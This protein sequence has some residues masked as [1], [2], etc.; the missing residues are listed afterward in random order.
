MKKVLFDNGVPKG[1]ASSVVGHQ[2]T[3]SRQLGWHLLK[4]GDLL[5]QAETGGFDVLL[6]TDK[7][8]QHQQ[9]LK[10]R[11]IAL[12]VL[13]EQRWSMVQQFSDQIVDAVNKAEPGSYTEV[14]IPWRPKNK[15][16]IVKGEH[17]PL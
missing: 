17:P 9:N 14:D 12:V 16:Q 11:R 7:N 1:I 13:K 5:K 10:E 3:R 8:I 4:N 2:V 15:R 6:S